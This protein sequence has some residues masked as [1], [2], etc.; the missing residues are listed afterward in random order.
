MYHLKQGDPEPEVSYEKFTLYDLKFCPFC[1]RVRYTLDYHQI[2]YDRVLVN[3]LCKPDWY[4]RL[5]PD[6]KVPL[7][8]FRDERLV[9]SDLVML[10]VDQFNGK[11][12]TS[13]LNVCG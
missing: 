10:F 4:Y 8:R 11:P 3:T 2:P 7:L 1:Q 5:N 13:L 6:G 12:E 9:E